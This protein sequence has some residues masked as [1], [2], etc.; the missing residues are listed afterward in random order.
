M[1]LAAGAR[2]G[3]YEILGLL[4][5]GGMG[6][7][8]LARDTRLGR[9]VAIKVLPADVADN[10]ER[11]ARFEREARTV[12]ALNHPNIVTLHDVAEAG[13]VRFLVMERVAGRTLADLIDRA[14]ELPPAR[15]L[16]LMTPVA[17][18]LA[19][20]HER[21]I[22]HR[23]LKPANI[24]VADDGRVK[25]LD[26]GLATER[27][28]PLD[29]EGTT[30]AKD[31]LTTE[32]RV[33]GTVS[34]MAPEQVRGERVDARADLFAFGVILYEMAAGVRPFRGESA[35][36]VASA[37]V[38]NEPPPIETIAPRVPAGLARIVRRCLEK[39]VR[40]R[41]Q[42]ALDLRNELEDVAN[43]ASRG[44]V[45]RPADLPGPSRV[46]C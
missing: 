38:G 11:L 45:P 8:Y 39:D 42:S 32:G 22:V 43:D 15:M 17:D 3:A 21:G 24:M 10:P 33:L 18:A 40:H 27:A 16:D 26:F 19:S 5:A 23:D 6:E 28:H 25:I 1:A 13:G 46:G 4:G 34:Y 36:D 7:V 20:A 30:V 29:G 12:A 35:I 2:L 31:A 37:I 44:Q 14:G 9:E 41:L